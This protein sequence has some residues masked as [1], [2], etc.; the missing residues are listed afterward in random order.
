MTVEAA[1]ATADVGVE[2]G[3]KLGLGLE[4]V[5]EPPEDTPE[6]DPEPELDPEVEPELGAGLAA[7]VAVGT[8]DEATTVE[9][10][11]KATADE[12]GWA[13]LAVTAD[14]AGAEP[15]PA[16]ELGPV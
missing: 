9:A 12:D 4:P 15:D 3:P 8:E 5:P 6:F 2:A 1:G 11:T 10:C 7:T 14:A 16:L 13:E